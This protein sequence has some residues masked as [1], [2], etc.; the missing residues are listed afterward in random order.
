MEKFWKIDWASVFVPTESL[1]EVVLRG[2]IL[3]FVMFAFL[4]IFRRQS[5]TI[6][7]ADLLVVVAIA[8]AAQNG[9]IG[10]GKSV[11]EAIFL[12][13]TF[14]LWNYLFDWLGYRFKFF[15]R[16]LEPKP[17]MLVRDGKFLLRNMRREMITKDEIE[18]KMRENGIEDVS[19]IKSAYMESDG[20]F[21]FIKKEKG[22]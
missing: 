12:I 5:G 18:S 6:S 10:D 13:T 15:E 1:F 20:N 7:T 11:T 17:L 22:S 14:F 9:M 16:L 8:D 21:S 4:R 2:T 3:Y 19:Q